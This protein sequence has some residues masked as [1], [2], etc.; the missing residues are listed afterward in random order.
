MKYGKIHDWICPNCKKTDG[1]KKFNCTTFPNILIIHV[2]RF[3]TNEN[4]FI[5][6]EDSLHYPISEM[7][8]NKYS[9]DNENDDDDVFDD[10]NE[11]EIIYELIG[12]IVHSGAVEFGHYTSYCKNPQTET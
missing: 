6:N 7:K 4:K 10:S 2:N 1:I 9:C 3:I 5:K 8:I 12:V 11:N